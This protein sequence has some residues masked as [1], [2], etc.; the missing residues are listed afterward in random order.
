MR[1][2]IYNIILY[3]ITGRPVWKGWPISGRSS[4]CRVYFSGVHG[5][6]GLILARRIEL[7]GM[8]GVHDQN[9]G[10]ILVASEK[11]FRVHMSYFPHWRTSMEVIKYCK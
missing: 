5:V 10:T 6:H 8:N 9:L 11:N 1:K 3:S 4:A 2:F 7:C